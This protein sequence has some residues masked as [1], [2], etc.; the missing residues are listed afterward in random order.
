MEPFARREMQQHQGEKVAIGRADD[1]G[2]K[3]QTVRGAIPRGT[4]PWQPVY[5]GI[6]GLS[7]H[8]AARVDARDRKRLERWNNCGR[9]IT[10][11]E[12]RDNDCFGAAKVADGLRCARP[13]AEPP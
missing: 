12:A 8:G 6:E 3:M 11:R 9:Y 13:S 5:V 4:A 1:A 10:W 7:L 2:H